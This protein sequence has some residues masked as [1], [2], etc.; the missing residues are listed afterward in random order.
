MLIRAAD[1][2]LLIGRRAAGTRYG[3]SWCLRGGYV[4]YE[5]SFIETAHREVFEETGIDIQL[6]GIVN[7]VS[8]HLDDW[9]HT[10]V[11]VLLADLLAGQPV[12]G[13]DLAELK[14]IDAR[15]HLGADYAFE[16]DQRI[17]DCYFAGN[18]KLLPIDERIE[19][20]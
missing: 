8:T 4:E 5:E 12:A 17:I 6:K 15:L 11:I 20:I 13:D 14:W 7:V 3:N 10:L 18:M 2:K 1:G 9:H 16:A 19:K